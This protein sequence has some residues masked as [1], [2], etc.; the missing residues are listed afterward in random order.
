[1]TFAVLRALHAI[2]GDAL[3]DIQ[4]VHDPNPFPEPREST[5][6]HQHLRIQ[7]PWIFLLWICSM[8]LLILQSSLRRT[9]LW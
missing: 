1:M 5:R 9:Q 2:I 6:R 4:R 8:T 7:V 3:D